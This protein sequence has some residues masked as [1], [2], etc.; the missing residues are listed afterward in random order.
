VLTLSPLDKFVLSDSHVKQSTFNEHE[1]VPM[2]RLVAAEVGKDLGVDLSV[3]NKN[4]GGGGSC[5]VEKGSVVR[6]RN[7]A[8]K[9]VSETLTQPD[10][11]QVYL[12]CMR[13][14]LSDED[15]ELKRAELRDGPYES[16]VGMFKGTCMAVGD[17][18]GKAIGMN[19]LQFS[20]AA[21]AKASYASSGVRGQH[22]GTAV[23]RGPKIADEL[24]RELCLTAENLKA[25]VRN[26][27]WLVL[28]PIKG[29]MSTE[30]QATQDAV[31]NLGGE[32]VVTVG[33]GLSSTM[34]S[35]TF[36]ALQAK[37]RPPQ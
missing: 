25:Y 31:M 34:A 37:L 3:W 7:S 10:P 26:K 15:K 30:R 11:G 23:E 6:R 21:E 33:A 2:L 24:I 17:A 8:G 16:Q 4:L 20:S 13:T 28:K 14:Y 19:C 1:D 22:M 27:S 12:H 18:V 5:K 29:T 35:S 36:E 32:L 9:R